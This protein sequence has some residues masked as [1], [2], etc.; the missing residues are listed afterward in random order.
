M[1]P[2]DKAWMILKRQTTLGEFHPDFPSPYGPVTMR[3]LHPLESWFEATDLGQSIPQEDR[4]PYEKLIREGLK[5]VPASKNATEWEDMQFMN[6][7]KFG[8]DRYKPFDMEGKSGNWV[9]PAG[10]SG[11]GWN[12]YSDAEMGRG[13]LGIRM[14]IEQVEGMFRNRGYPFGGKDEPAEGFITQHIPPELLVRLPDG[15]TGGP[16]H[17]GE[18]GEIGVE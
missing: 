3:R 6:T 7:G 13:R 14:P 12:I 2:M 15:W 9:F 11:G 18:R 16:S 1:T 17:F 4:Q 10:A 8:G 5:P